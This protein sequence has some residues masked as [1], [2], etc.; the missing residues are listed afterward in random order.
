MRS[1][2]VLHVFNQIAIAVLDK[3]A[4]PP[5]RTYLSCSNT[6]F[7]SRS[8]GQLSPSPALTVSRYLYLC[9]HTWRPCRCLTVDA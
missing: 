5:G 2:I 9:H 7:S 4:A 8:T 1:S 3:C 6:A